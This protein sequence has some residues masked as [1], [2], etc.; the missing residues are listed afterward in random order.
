[1]QRES[2][3]SFLRGGSSDERVLPP[4]RIMFAGKKGF[5]CSAGVSC[6]FLL[7][8]DGLISNAGAITLA[9]LIEAEQ[10]IRGPAKDA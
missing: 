4:P 9:E 5:P 8:V 2:R 6:R 7:A 10:R 3:M 1:M